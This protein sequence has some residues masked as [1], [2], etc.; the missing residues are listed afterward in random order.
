VDE[1]F[2]R[3]KADRAATVAATLPPPSPPVITPAGP[4]ESTDDN[5][6]RPAA[7]LTH[8]APSSPAEPSGAREIEDESARSRR[9]EL[10][11]PVEEAL[12][13][14]LKRV[15]QDEQ[16][17]VLDRLRRKRRRNGG[18]VLLSHDE[19]AGRFREAAE[20]VLADAVRAGV[21]FADPTASEAHADE[22]A[23]RE[24]AEALAAEVTEPLRQRLERTL[25][26][27]GGD[28][29]AGELSEG[30]SA[31][32]RQWRA[33]ELEPLAR[34]HAI[35]AF[36]R[37]AYAA[38]PEGASLRWVVEDEVPCP[39]CDD[40]ELAG[41]VAKGQAYPTGQPHPPAHPGCRCLLT[42]TVP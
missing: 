19:Q 32:Y 39:D 31:V 10:L 41:A 13:R 27:P 37:G 3:I 40:N 36:S 21:R 28:S 6:S 23:A 8:D 26:E 15:L 30:A 9:D 18:S 25:G 22:R 29:D 4:P 17:E 16:N 20:S 5:G 1:L 12:V 24:V 33:Q 7:E 38:Y 35:L 2:A 11:A 14:Q 42:P 34:H